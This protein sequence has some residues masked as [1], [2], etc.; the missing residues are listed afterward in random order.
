[1]AFESFAS[2]LVDGDTNS[3]R[4]VFVHD[5]QTG[6]T[7]RVSIASDG[8]QATGFSL[9]PSLSDDGRFVAFESPASNLV[10]GD[11]NSSRDTFVH[12]RQTGTTQRVS[13][14]SDGAQA[15]GF[16]DRPFL[17]ADGR[18]VA[19]RSSAPNLV[20]GD[21]NTTDDIFVHDRQTG[22]TQR[23]SV[24]SSQ[25]TG[26]S[27][28]PSLSADGRFVA[29]GSSA[30][31]LVDG[32]TNSSTDIFVH[33]RQTGTTQR[34]SIASDGAQATGFS[35]DPSLSADGRFVAFVSFAP[36]LVDGDTNS[37]GDIFV[38]DRQT[39]TTQRVSVA[40][41]GAQATDSSYDP[42]LSADGRFVAFSSE[43]DNLVSGDTNDRSDIFVHDRLLGITQRVSV[44]SDGSEGNGGPSYI[45]APGAEEPSISADGRFVAFASYA[46]NLV[47]GDTNGREDVFVH[48]RQTGTTQR[49]SVASDGAQASHTGFSTNP[50]LSADGRFVAFESF[51]PNLVDGDT[52]SSRDTFVHDRQT[53]TTQRVSVASDGAQATDSSYDPALSADGRFVAFSSEADNLV[54]RDTNDRSDIFVHDR[55]LG[56]TQRVS[57]ASDGIQGNFSSNTPSIS[58]DGRFVAFESFATNLVS[59]DTNRE[60]DVF[61]ASVAP[62]VIRGMVFVDRN[63]DGIEQVIDSLPG[64][65]ADFFKVFADAD[66]NGVFNVGEKIGPVDFDGNFELVVDPGEYRVTLL[67]PSGWQ[68]TTAP[69]P[70]VSVADS[71]VAELA[72][73]LGYFE[74]GVVSGLVWED[75][76]RDAVRQAFEDLL[77]NRTVDLIP[78]DAAFASSYASGAVNITIDPGPANTIESQ[79]HVDSSASIV[80][81]NLSLDITHTYDSD[82]RITLISPKGTKVMVVNRRGASDDNFTFTTLDDEASLSI[83]DAFAPFTGNFIPEN[84]LAAFDGQTAAGLWTLRIE[85]MA[86]IDGG[87]LNGWQLDL[88]LIDSNDAVASGV[89]DVQGFYEIHNIAAGTYYLH[90]RTDPEW[91]AVFPEGVRLITISPDEQNTEFDFGQQR[92]GGSIQ[93]RVF[94]DLDRDGDFDANELNLGGQV[95]YLD[96]DSD[97]QLSVSDTRSFE[98]DFFEPTSVFVRNFDNRVTRIDIE[99]VFNEETSF[100]DQWFLNSPLGEFVTDNS[101]PL[102]LTD[103]DLNADPNGIWSVSNTSRPFNDNDPS[104]EDAFIEG[105]KITI[106]G[107]EPVALSKAETGEYVFDGLPPGDYIVRM[108]ADTEGDYLPTMQD[109]YEVTI[110]N[111]ELFVGRDFHLGFDGVLVTSQG[112][113]IADA[114]GAGPGIQLNL[115]G[116]LFA[117]EEALFDLEV[118]NTSSTPVT[119][120]S[121]DSFTVSGSGRDIFSTSDEFHYVYHPLSGDGEIIAQVTSQ[122]NTHPW[123]KAAVMIRDTLEADSKFAM[124]TLTAEHGVDFQYRETAGE[125]VGQTW[126]S[127]DTEIHGSNWLRIVRD[128]DQFTAYHSA[129]GVNWT[130]FDSNTIPMGDNIHIGLAVTSHNDGVLSEAR[131]EN[132]HVF[133]GGVRTN[134]IRPWQNLDV[135]SVAAFGDAVFAFLSPPRD[136][137]G[138]GWTFENAPYGVTLQPGESAPIQVR[139]VTDVIG[140]NFGDS[141]TMTDS[142]GTPLRRPFITGITQIATDD[143]EINDDPANLNLPALL[144]LDDSTQQ[145]TIDR[146]LSVDPGGQLTQ[147]PDEDWFTFTLTEPTSLFFEVTAPDLLDL[148]GTSEDLTLLLYDQIEDVRRMSAV[149]NDTNVSLEILPGDPLMVDDDSGAGQAP[150]LVTGELPPG[151]YFLQAIEGSLYKQYP[152]GTPTDTP[153][154]IDQGT[155]SN[156]VK[157]YLISANM[158]ILPNQPPTFTKGSDQIIDEDAGPQTVN[159]WATNID[160]GA[161]NESDQSLQFLVSNDNNSLF[162]VQP[163]ISPDGTLTYTPADEAFGTATVTVVLQDDGGTDNGGD[164]TAD[165]QTVNITVN[166]VND[167]PTF[168]KGSDQII[169]EDAGPQTVNNWAT[170]IDAG[171]ANE[172]DQSLQ[173]LVSNDN[174]SLFSVQPTIS[175]DG[176]LTYTPAD[177]AFGT[178][179]VTVVLQDD[180]GTDNGGDDTADT[181]IY[182]ITIN[183]TPASIIARHVIYNNSS[184]D[185]DDVSANSADDAAIDPTKSALLPGGQASFSN[186]SSYS[187]GVNGLMV[188]VDNLAGTPTADD[189]DFKVGN[190]NDPSSWSSYTGLIDIS[191]RSGD[192]DNGSDRITLIFPDGTF[193]KTWLQV[194]IKAT[195]NTGL[196][197]DDV[198][199]FGNAVGETG[200]N[201]SNAN[202]NA[203]DTGGVRDNPRNFLNPA[204]V[205]NVYDVNK[206]S[207]VNAFD[208]GLARDNAT[209]LLNSLKLIAVPSA[210]TSPDQVVNTESIDTTV[211]VLAESKPMAVSKETSVDS[212]SRMSFLWSTWESRQQTTDAF[213]L[214]DDEDI[215][216]SELS[217]VQQVLHPEGLK[218]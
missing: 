178:A 47:S 122:Q 202:V 33:D 24:A 6:T 3:S 216:P 105:L 140:G 90:Q 78:L 218:L 98:S 1:V 48:D 19:F 5:R 25:A 43:A 59:G 135:G 144:P 70:L 102:T 13:I 103:I 92:S 161:A 176:T 39:G 217:M 69:Q 80:D 197:T 129:D 194:T 94:V 131:F 147:T 169:D 204:S 170:N 211:D 26:S 118:W 87:A 12:D 171:A 121:D 67:E 15:T 138:R 172:S 174:N 149:Q 7:Q 132:V 109:G 93:G 88:D 127:V 46:D 79:I 188:D 62:A 104:G 40:S 190:S 179:T 153:L 213:G 22:T 50:S 37:S 215:K 125:S 136:S 61:V 4:D 128:G 163:T 8:A 23:V 89:T 14:A 142:T 52:N 76:N 143:F 155:F 110:S 54:S 66:G 107:T 96:L 200:D 82:L 198:F 117:G 184:F 183:K 186:Y 44:A 166:P 162:S 83:S 203:F 2:N 18:F 35:Y 151:D 74:F 134:E 130:P 145:H 152:D 71:E 85:D 113:S 31:N 20:D 97:G 60:H 157:T 191:V 148:P 120:G 41:D 177:E 156:V 57:V 192:G 114:P 187:K 207:F 34:V 116:K 63:A 212:S 32:D 123:A 84:P 214:Q 86:N 36:N 164:D 29:F 154:I 185:G 165:T 64:D 141:G 42:A 77:L 205:E 115:E 10:D 101:V 168:T 139:F 167:A 65:D 206:D 111:D 112:Q 173:F 99:P 55:L 28:N 91:T 182:G 56:I 81:L 159:N 199:Y 17:S 175:P 146:F 181:Q 75:A 160:A 11:T 119:L 208:F 108:E 137:A 27:E 51:A 106:S 73:K 49:V 209:G 53:G 201:P 72:S 195:A 68:V 100:I 180:G 38:H 158:G 133:D 150:L 16:S 126:T 95:L 196:V 45:G 58:A 124:T 21:T 9:N 189:F 30:P 193:T 210:L